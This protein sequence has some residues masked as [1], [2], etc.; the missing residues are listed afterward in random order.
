MNRNKHEEERRKVEET[1]AV[2][3]WIGWIDSFVGQLRHNE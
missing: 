3:R 2:G 1:R